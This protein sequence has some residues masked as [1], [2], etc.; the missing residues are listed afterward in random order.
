MAYTSHGYF[1]NLGR[2]KMSTQV[3]ETEIGRILKRNNVCPPSH[4]APASC[5]IE[6]I[7]ML[8]L[9]RLRSVL[10]ICGID[11]FTEDVFDDILNTLVPPE[12]HYIWDSPRYPFGELVKE[13]K[14]AIVPFSPIDVYRIVDEPSPNPQTRS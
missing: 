13:G 4:T 5:T 10:K 7:K 9:G 8:A 6:E 12:H 14:M 3:A 1:E 2:L 11:Y